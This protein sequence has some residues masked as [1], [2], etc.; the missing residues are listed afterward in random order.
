MELDTYLPAYYANTYR[1]HSNMR[2]NIMKYTTLSHV[3]PSQVQA[4]NQ[5]N[6]FIMEYT[7]LLHIDP[8]Q[9]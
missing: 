6:A 1:S 4:P 8:S 5:E 3:D 7:T 9:V 2:P